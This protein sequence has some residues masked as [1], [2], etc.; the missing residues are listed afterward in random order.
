MTYEPSPSPSL[1]PPQP[2]KQ[3]GTSINVA[4]D[5]GSPDPLVGSE[6]SGHEWTDA[7]G[8]RVYF[9]A[10]EETDPLSESLARALRHA[11][12]GLFGEEGSDDEDDLFAFESDATSTDLNK[13][14]FGPSARKE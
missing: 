14:L 9:S 12:D 5:G 4:L 3:Q 2:Y 8:Q 13:R 10:G 6:L 1:Q 11:E 7:A